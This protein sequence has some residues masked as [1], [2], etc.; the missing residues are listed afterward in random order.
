MVRILFAV[1]LHRRT[2]AFPLTLQNLGS[3]SFD[4]AEIDVTTLAFGPNGATEFHGMGHIEDVNS[5]EI[6][7]MVLHFRTPHTGIACGD[8]SASITGELLDGTPIE[9]TDS[10]QTVGCSSNRRTVNGR[11]GDTRQRGAGN[12]P[13][14][15]FERK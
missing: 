12:G 15:T 10:I 11:A 5:D 14:S 6:P 2:F 8:E 13:S 7:D 4:V 3:D 1:F 9:G